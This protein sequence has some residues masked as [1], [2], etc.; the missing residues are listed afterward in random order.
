MLIAVA[1]LYSEVYRFLNGYYVTN[2]YVIDYIVPMGEDSP[3]DAKN[4]V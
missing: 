3:L 1:C 4:K 2:K